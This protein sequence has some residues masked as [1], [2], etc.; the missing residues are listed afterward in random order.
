MLI[1]PY[2]TWARHYMSYPT[3]FMLSVFMNL[4]ILLLVWIVLLA[5]LTIVKKRCIGEH[6][7]SSL[8]EER[9]TSIIADDSQPEKS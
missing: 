1:F 9:G 2:E 5:V 7:P 4:A 8:V 3:V 6:S